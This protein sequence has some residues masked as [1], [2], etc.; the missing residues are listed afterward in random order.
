M[1]SFFKIAVGFFCVLWLNTAQANL[2][3]VE[4]VSVEAERASALEAKE[5][6]LAQGQV[7][8]FRRL[9][10]RLSPEN[11]ELMPEITEEEILPYVAGVS[12]ENEKTTATKYMGS[13]AV[14]FYPS[15]VKEF[16][17]AQQV[18]YLRAQAPSL[19]VI[20]EYVVNGEVQ[21]LEETNPLYLALKERGN[22]APFYQAVVPEGT[23]DELALIQQDLRAAT[24]LLNIYQKDKVMVLRLEFEEND[25]WGIRSSFYPATGM[26]NQVVYK[27]FR[28]GSGNPKLAALQMADAVFKEMERRWRENRTSSFADKQTLYLRVNVNSLGEWLALSKAMKTWSFFENITLKGVYLPQVLVEATYK[29][30]EEKIRSDLLDNGWQLIRDFSGNGATLTRIG[31]DE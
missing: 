24:N 2:Y 9:I 17:N 15:A 13:I 14:E 6:A 11:K 30:D 16:L 21:L 19:L 8:A 3:R 25:M 28:I 20:P 22:F 12:I 23:E 27:R 10:A 31:N 4:N 5:A 29:G 26:Q 1:K 18:T 7:A